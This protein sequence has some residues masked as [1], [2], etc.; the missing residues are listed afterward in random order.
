MH[1][2]EFARLSQSALIA[3]REATTTFHASNKGRFG[4]VEAVLTNDSKTAGDCINATSQNITARTSDELGSSVM[5]WRGVV[6]GKGACK[7]YSSVGSR[8]CRGGDED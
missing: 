6:G 1:T 3:T 8:M 5:S 2:E 4:A 7:D